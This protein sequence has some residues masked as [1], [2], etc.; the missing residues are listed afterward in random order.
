MTNHAPSFRLI[1]A[2]S[3]KSFIIK[4][5]PFDLTTRWHYHPEVELIYFIKGNTTAV[6]GD[7]F[8]EFREGDLVLLGANFPHVLQESKDFKLQNPE[9]EPFGLIIQFTE[10][11]LG[12]EFLIKP[13]IAVI[14]DLL[15]KAARGLQFMHNVSGKVKG[16][17]NRLP[18]QKDSRKLLYLLEILFTL[19]ETDDF[20]FLVHQEYNYEIRHDEERMKR[21]HE[22]VYKHFRE[23]ITITDV[24]SVAHMT[25]ASFCRYFKS[26]T[27]KTFSHFLNEIRIAYACK[28]LQEKNTTVTDACFASGF[29]SLPYFS[30]KF[31]Y[32]VKMSPQQYQGWKREAIGI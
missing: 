19:A 16:L 12:K 28:L 25:E 14:K 10:D 32:L 23:K 27:L 5:E 26:R 30:R 11:F 22:F 24:A 20:D 1:N 4:W 6:I 9:I 29:G 18:Q 31:K 21:I 7:V 17:L 2:P 3:D 13:E 8:K 15:Q